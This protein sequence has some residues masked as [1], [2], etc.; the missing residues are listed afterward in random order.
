M[1]CTYHVLFVHLS[2]NG[3]CDCFCLLAA[4]NN[5]AM[6][7]DVQ[8]FVPVLDFHSLEFNLIC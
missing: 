4:M 3:H 7:V 6:N 8:I 1:V 2:A 5:V